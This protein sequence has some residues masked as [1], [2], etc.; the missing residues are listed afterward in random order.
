M[1]E[2]AIKKTKKPKDASKKV[3]KPK[4]PS[5]KT[6]GF[7]KTFSEKM[8]ALY[9]L[10]IM[11]L[12]D[13]FSFSLAANKKGAIMKIVSYILGFILITAACFGIIYLAGF[14]N[15]F[16]LG[17]YVPVSAI[18]VLFTLMFA[19]SVITCLVG[20]T[21]TLYFSKD[22]QFL[23]AFPVAP[24]IVF[25][26]KLNVY[27][28][29]EIIKNFLFIVP[30][31]LAYGMCYNF[32]WYYYIWI[33]FCFLLIAALPVIIAAIL[34][35]IYMWVKIFFKKFPIANSAFIFTALFGIF[36]L[37]VYLMN[38]LPENINIIAQWGTTFWQIQ[39]FLNAWSE[40]LS[41]I[42][43]L[44]DAMVG[45]GAS[46]YTISLFNQYT[47]P[48]LGIIIGFIVV[49][50]LAAFFLAKPM[51]FKMATKPFEF[52]KKKIAHDYKLSKQNLESQIGA[53][54]FKIK[55]D[56]KQND[57]KLYRAILN[58]AWKEK[59]FTAKKISPKRILRILK[60]VSGL[61]FE[62]I[63][64]DQDTNLKQVGP[65]FIIL[66]EH[67]IN[68]LVLLKKFNKISY[69][70]FDP[71]HL[72]KTNFS[73]KTPFLSSLFKEFLLSLRA[74]EIIISN[75][76]LFAITPLATLLLNKIFSAMTTR[77]MG[78][79][80][81]IA[82]NV[83]IILLLM[84][85]SS[86][87][88][89]SIYSKEG[90]G[91]YL[92]KSAPVNYSKNLMSKLVINTFVMLLSTIATG[93]IFYITNNQKLSGVWLLFIAIF[94]IYLGHVL[95]SAELDFMNPQDKIYATSG[96]SVINPNETKSTIYAFAISFVLA[97]V[98]FFLLD[99][100]VGV[101]FL[102]IFFIGVVFFGARLYLFMARVRVYNTE[103]G[104]AGK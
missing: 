6:S 3:K 103:R 50:G 101:T 66:K 68:H 46:P 37:S 42:R 45:K 76:V 93:I 63:K 61:E 77:I 49:F 64:I 20:L 39:G 41:P 25:L 69:Y 7:G 28:F 31:F 19:L 67:D 84:L 34:S 12:K 32:V 23:L 102:K 21:D 96:V 40:V 59:F 52:N 38:L 100:D 14:L 35:L 81:V 13:K 74:P 8:K 30:L 85:S 71:I 47:L 17:G 92:L 33:L 83:L 27:Y 53:Y 95:W 16:S 9:I 62:H 55:D 72:D 80:M 88:F 90:A 56:E 78:G 4:E 51:F 86:I 99:E 94:L 60:D 57:E 36:G 10:T 89:A 75:F 11:Q 2:V 44:V 29:S 48:V 26:S 1:E 18:T 24:N 104:E 65:A 5:Q 43:S 98:T 82:F 70:L 22:N 54:V 87:S 73:A 97:L 58:K 91:S 79:Y 15:L